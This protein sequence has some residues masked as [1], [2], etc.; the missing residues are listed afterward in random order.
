MDDILIQAASVQQCILHCHIVI[1]VLMS[2]G[3]SFKWA[4]CDLVPKQKIRHLGFDFDLN[5]M[6]ISCPHEKVENLRKRCFEIMLRNIVMTVL[7]LQNYQLLELQLDQ[8]I[9]RLLSVF[10][11]W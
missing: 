1:I 4:K 9:G 11:K 7:L 5:Q 3:W 10:T 2:L 8:M 6:I